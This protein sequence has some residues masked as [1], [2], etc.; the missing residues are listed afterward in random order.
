ML[1][2]P[3]SICAAMFRAINKFEKLISLV[4][5]QK[6]SRIEGKKGR[7]RRRRKSKSISRFLEIESLLSS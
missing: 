7:E 1:N 3:G 4:A 2:I 5:N 6:L